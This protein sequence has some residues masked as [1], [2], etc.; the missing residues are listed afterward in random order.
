MNKN[1]I[2]I[3]VEKVSFEWKRFA[4]MTYLKDVDNII[5]AIDYDP[6][7]MREDL[8]VEMFLKKLYHHHPVDYMNF[9]E[10][11]LKKMPRNDVLKDLGF[12]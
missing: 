9:I 8:K 10:E 7:M 6:D 3:L 1:T 5:D 12:G 4:R 2:N 11:S